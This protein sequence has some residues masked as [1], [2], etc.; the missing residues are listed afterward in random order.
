M[1]EDGVMLCLCPDVGWCLCPDVGWCL[2]SF[3]G[4]GMWAV[5]PVFA[6]SFCVACARV[7]GCWLLLCWVFLGVSPIS[8]VVEWPAPGMWDFA[9]SCAILLGVFVSG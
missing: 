7:V 1:L 4:P 5:F 2:V 3:P 8:L 6:I 9:S